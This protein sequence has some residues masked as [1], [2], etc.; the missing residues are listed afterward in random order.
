[1][2]EKEAVK[3]VAKAVEEDMDQAALLPADPRLAEVTVVVERYVRILQLILEKNENT[4]LLP[5]WCFCLFIGR[6]QRRR[7][8]RWRTFRTRQRW[9]KG[10]Q[11]YFL[12]RLCKGKH[13]HIYRAA[14]AK[15]EAKV[16]VDTDHL[17]HLA[18]AEDTA[19][20]QALPVVEEEREAE[21]VDAKDLWAE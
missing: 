16:A 20:A 5:T 12:S 2:V 11:K 6:R 1:M 17:H 18:V 8:G 15:E 4:P 7:K 14:E 9:R 13:V 19:P 3:E 10:K 21:R